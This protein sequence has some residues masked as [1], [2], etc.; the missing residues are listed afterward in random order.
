M[1][2]KASLSLLIRT[3]FGALF[4]AASLVSADTITKPE[5]DES[6]LPATTSQ[7]DQASI[8]PKNGED[9]AKGLE[10]W[11]DI[12]QVLSHPRCVN[13]HVPDDRPRWS[14][15]HY[16]KPSVHGMNIQAT[17]TR[18]G[19]PG[20]QACST[21]HAKTNSDV[22]HGPPGA[23]VW[24]LAP[25]EMIWW[26][27][28]STELCSTVKDPDKTGGR[29]IKAF[30]DHIGHDPLVAWAWN[31]GSDREPAPFSVKETVAMLEHWL[32][33]GLPCPE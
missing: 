24:A 10:V 26:G 18:V 20:Q 1:K 3:A 7:T 31:P 13:C 28:S 2:F 8:V 21:C 25:A 27:K 32:A 16:G 22:P 4:L 29:D 11:N 23:K 19:I 6:A 9:K 5:S 30:A 15:K 17:A 33:L 14:G 12:Y